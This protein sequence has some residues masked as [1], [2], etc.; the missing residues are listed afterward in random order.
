MS[1]SFSLSF[2]PIN[3]LNTR[4]PGEEQSCKMKESSVPERSSGRPATSWEH[5]HGT[6]YVEERNIH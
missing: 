6:L 3:K 2:F 1:V 5:S 4:S